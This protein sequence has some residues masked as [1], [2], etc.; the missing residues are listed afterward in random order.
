MAPL[1]TPSQARHRQS[2]HSF[3]PRATFSCPH[4]PAPGR[5]MHARPPSTF[6]PCYTPPQALSSIPPTKQPPS[7]CPRYTFLPRPAAA[8]GR[9]ECVH[10]GPVE[11]AALLRHLPLGGTTAQGP[12]FPCLPRRRRCTADADGALCAVWPFRAVS[13]GFQVWH[14]RL[15]LPFGRTVAASG[16]CLSS[17]FERTVF[18]HC[19]NRLPHRCSADGAGVAQPACYRAAELL[20][21]RHGRPCRCDAHVM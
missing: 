19:G 6:Y 5:P 1:L 4:R 15:P 10:R 8:Q 13:A 9:L 7:C 21:A 16:A 20:L 12:R 11:V 2:R 14:S 17:L 3:C 18:Y